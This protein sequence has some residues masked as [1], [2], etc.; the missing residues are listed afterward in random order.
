MNPSE[1]PSTSPDTLSS[2]C[3]TSPDVPSCSSSSSSTQTVK[4][5]TNNGSD[6]C[7]KYDTDSITAYL[8]YKKSHFTIVD[9]NGSAS[10]WKFFGLPAK[11]LGPDKYEI[12]PKFASCKSCYRTYSY[13]ST[14]TTLSNHKCPVL[15]NTTQSKL[16]ML[17]ISR[18]IPSSPFAQSKSNDKQK[19]SF[20]TLL[21]D[22]ICSNTRPINIVQDDGLKSIIDF[23]IQIGIAFNFF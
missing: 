15:H 3:A 2:L 22:W 5:D 10:C 4:I 18:P 14:T 21:S 13:S 8:K 19:A 7:E 11:I 17:P 6:F 16:Q 1:S 12:I 9:K 23:C 20:T